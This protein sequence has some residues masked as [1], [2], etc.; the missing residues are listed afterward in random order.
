MK[1]KGNCLIYLCTCEKK[2]VIDYLN[3]LEDAIDNIS[4]EEVAELFKEIERKNDV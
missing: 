4:D 2:E 3:E 1:H